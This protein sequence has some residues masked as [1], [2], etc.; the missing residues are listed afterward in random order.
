[1]GLAA[2]I[3]EL[4]LLVVDHKR[5]ARQRTL[6]GRRFFN[7]LFKAV[8]LRSYR[9]LRRLA[10]EIGEVQPTFTIPEDAGFVLWQPSA[11]R[12]LQDAIAEANAIFDAAD[13][14]GL[15]RAMPE[16]APFTHIPY[17]PRP[18]SAIARLATHAALIKPFAE[19]LGVIPVLHA[20]QLMYSPNHRLVQ[21]S[22]QYYHLDGQDT[23]S[24]QVFV[25]LQD[26][27]EDN[28]PLTLLPA[29]VSERVA[30]GLRYRKA[31]A[32]RR[33]D[34]E[35]IARSAGPDRQVHV[36]TG[37]KGSVLVFDGDRCFHYGSR[38]ATRPRR[39]LHYAYVTPFAFTLPD[40]WWEKFGH[41]VS[42]DAPEWQRRVVRA[43]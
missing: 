27:S 24:L 5:Y 8:H 4:G 21:G 7:A 19:Y 20:L 18:E 3:R 40:R 25:Y 9:R 37:P 16:D 33:I 1:M 13:L 32:S 30:E 6:K 31:A 42:R 10:S 39:I 43:S 26:V 35:V 14:E 29:R 17:E 11:F 22:S 2:D 28:G 15:T 38:K 12:P 23:K 34:D 41:L 36:L